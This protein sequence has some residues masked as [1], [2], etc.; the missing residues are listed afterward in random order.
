MR[1]HGMIGLATLILVGCAGILGL[2]A[3]EDAASR[4]PSGTTEDGSAGRHDGGLDAAD[5]ADAGGHGGTAAN[6]IVVCGDLTCRLDQAQVC[7]VTPPESN[8]PP[9]YLFACAAPGACSTGGNGSATLACASGRNCGGST[10][11]CCLTK[12]GNGAQ[13]V[14]KVACEPS[15]ATLCAPN[16]GTECPATCSTSNIRTW[17]LP[18]TYATCGGAAA[19]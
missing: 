12:V 1:I 17:D 16:G 3:Y 15:E 9:D 7:C 6:P 13:S 18:D 19:P 10:P 4:S 5:A 11:V 8:P 14:C 2:D